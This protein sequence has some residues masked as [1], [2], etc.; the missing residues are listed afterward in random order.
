[1]KLFT[2]VLLLMVTSFAHAEILSF[3]N[4]E[5]SSWNDAPEVT[6]TREE[7]R[8]PGLSKSETT[9][10]F[11][12]LV[13]LEKD[14]DELGMAIHRDKLALKERKSNPNV[15]SD[16]LIH[17][18]SFTNEWR[19][20]DYIQNTFKAHLAVL[21]PLLN[22]LHSV[23]EGFDIDGEKKP[24]TCIV[25]VVE[26]LTGDI[27]TDAGKAEWTQLEYALNKL[28]GGKPYIMMNAKNRCAAIKRNLKKQF[29]GFETIENEEAKLVV[30]AKAVQS[31][32]DRSAYTWMIRALVDLKAIEAQAKVDSKY[33]YRLA[34]NEVIIHDT[35]GI[36]EWYLNPFAQR[37]IKAYVAVLSNHFKSYDR[38]SGETYYQAVLTKMELLNKSLKMDAGRANQS[39]QDKA[40]KTLI[41]R[42]SYAAKLM[43]SAIETRATG[44]K[45]FTV[46]TNSDCLKQA[47]ANTLYGIS[48]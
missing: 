7:L 8:I 20:K 23:S 40:F 44:K 1:M 32:S 43:K 41:E 39:A 47:V 36:N 25:D 35:A 4:L 2:L 11:R 12:W 33:E 29:T 34:E 3:D 31:P 22:K 15:Y 5:N 27:E 28:E 21:E 46:I 18:R 17:D 24:Y 14:I 30:S 26:K 38:A 9:Q 37:A 45:Q 19:L 42:A 13:R 6:E 10:L 16:V 48:R